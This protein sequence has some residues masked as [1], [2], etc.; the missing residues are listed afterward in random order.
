MKAEQSKIIQQPN[1]PSFL[2]RQES[3]IHGNEIPDRASLV[4]NDELEE[5]QYQGKSRRQV[6]GSY[7]IFSFCLFM[8]LFST[9]M[10]LIANG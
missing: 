2:R 7:K 5:W 4:R 8:V 10:Y 1:S 6:A 3:D 9:L